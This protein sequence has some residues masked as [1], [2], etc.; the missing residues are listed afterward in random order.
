[1]SY[2]TDCN[3]PLSKNPPAAATIATVRGFVLSFNISTC[4]D[5]RPE[6]P[7]HVWTGMTNDLRVL[8]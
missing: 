1:M 7:E 6:N 3:A 8:Y 2:E 4:V 5:G